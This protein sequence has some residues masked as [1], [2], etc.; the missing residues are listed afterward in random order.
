MFTVHYNKKTGLQDIRD[1]FYEDEFVAIFA[2]GTPKSEEPMQETYGTYSFDRMISN[3]NGCFAL[4]LF[5]KKNGDL[6]AGRD[7]LGS[8]Q[9]YYY[10]NGDDVIVST[11]FMPCFEAAGKNINTVALQHYFTFQYVPEPLTIGEGVC[12]VRAGHFVRFYEGD[13]VSTRFNVWKPQPRTKSDKAAF[14]KEIRAAMKKAVKESIEGAD[15]VAAFLSGGLDSSI[16]TALASKD[17]PDMTAYTIAF[18]VPGFSEADV[19]ARSAGKYGIKHEVVNIDSATFAAEVPFAVKAMGVPVADPSAVAVSLIAKAAAGKCDVIL[20]GEGSDELWGGYHV[21]NPRGRVLKIKAIPGPI[22]KMIWGIVKHASEDTKGKDLIRR[23]CV[24]LRDR[25]VGNTFLL[26]EDE[27]K[28]LLRDYKPNV[29]FTDITSSYFDE[30]K[31]LSEMDMMQYIDTNLW[32][33]GDINVVCGKGCSERGL[34]CETPF[35][36]NAV[37]DLARTLTRSEKV[38]GGQ[39]KIVLRET[40]E[41]IITQEVKD[42]KKKGYPVPVRIWLSGELNEWA[43]NVIRT[44]DVD[45]YINKDAALKY[46][47]KCKADPSNP[48][49]YRKAWAIVV[50]CV[51]KKI[52]VD[53]K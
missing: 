37:T 10:V 29:R 4:V 8:K 33:P 50:F 18:D 6:Y 13:P 26:G 16:I 7:R 27:K 25:F 42:G 19:A 22:K 48:V 28:K 41:D 46:L 53:G 20:S 44:A 45:K 15:R 2:D 32:L 12:A 47:D 9:L 17:R 3:L 34:H 30:T 36:D 38:D 31:G 43:R 35:M 51:W 1:A 11:H 5:D 24:P 40:F 52:M 14:R 49:Y 39:N 23:G 21:Y